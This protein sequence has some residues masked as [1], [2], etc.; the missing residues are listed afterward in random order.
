MSG[1]TTLTLSVD[2]SGLTT[3]GTYEA[4]VP[5]SATDASNS[6]RSLVVTLV[7]SPESS[8][9]GGGC[10]APAG[11]GS[12]AIWFALAGL[13]AAWLFRSRVAERA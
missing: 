8:S 13:A 5:V 10:T 11:G 9:N 3:E 12:S 7:L 6:P 1:T 2:A 4:T